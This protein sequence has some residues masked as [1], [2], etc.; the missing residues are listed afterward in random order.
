MNNPAWTTKQECTIYLKDCVK[1]GNI[2]YLPNAS[3][4]TYNKFEKASPTNDEKK[5]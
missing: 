2:C 5:N 1:A 3:C 4:G